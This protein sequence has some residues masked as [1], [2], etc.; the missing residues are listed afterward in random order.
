MIRRILRNRH[1]FNSLIVRNA[2]IV[3]FFLFRPRDYY[4]LS[5]CIT[6][7]NTFDNL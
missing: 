4:K 1:P 5:L 3:L 2:Y 6:F 7:S